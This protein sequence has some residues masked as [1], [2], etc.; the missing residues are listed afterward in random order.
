MDGHHDRAALGAALRFAVLLTTILVAVP[1]SAQMN[2]EVMMKWSGV[3][4]VH[5][6]VVGDYEG[7]ATVVQAGTN[8]IA[9][10]R[11]HVEITFDY[12]IT[13]GALVGPAT[14]KDA[15]T[16]VGAIRNG[17]KGCRPPTLSGAYEHSTIESLKQG[18]SGQLAMRSGPTT[19]A[20]K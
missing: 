11:D 4:V 18:L 3:H 8:G 10:V 19:P 16:Q 13:Q 6:S 17:A 5:F 15:A 1:A 9:P 20:L 14:F 12:D 2:R 7:E